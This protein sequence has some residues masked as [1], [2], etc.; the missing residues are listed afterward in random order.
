MSVRPWK[1]FTQWW[2]KALTEAAVCFA[3]ICC[4]LFGNL[5]GA[6]K[7]SNAGLEHLHLSFELIHHANQISNVLSL[8]HVPFLY[9]LC[10][11]AKP[12]SICRILE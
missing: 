9:L 11:R 2:L 7:L 8:L 3:R 6:L 1:S 10:V 4:L 5:L 12:L